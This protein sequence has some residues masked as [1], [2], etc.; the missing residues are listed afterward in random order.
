MRADGRAGRPVWWRPEVAGRDV[1]LALAAT[2][3]PLPSAV[4]ARLAAGQD[5]VG[6]LRPYSPD[7]AGVAATLGDLGLRFV[8][9]GDREWPLDASPPDPPCAWLFMAGRAPPGPDAAVAVVG[10]RRASPLR[11]AAA[12][13]LAAGLAAAGWWVVSGGAVGVDAAAH[14]GALDG[15]GRT[16]AVLGCGLDVV[17]PR[18]NGPLFARIVAEGGT[19]LSEHPPGAPPR[20]AHF[21]PR[22]RLIA[23]LAAAVVVVEAAEGSGSLSTA[24]AAGS[25]GRGRVLVVPGAPWDPGAAGSNELLRDGGTLVR[26]LDDILEELEA[27]TPAGGRNPP[28]KPWPQVAGPAARAVLQALVDGQVVGPARLAATTDLTPE[29]IADAVLEL[30]LAGLVR[31]TAAGFQFVA[32]PRPPGP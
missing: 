21:V 29:V 6:L 23:A 32:L 28:A 18:A 19:L 17:Y 3:G 16:V 25:R 13:S 27:P 12:R 10:G 9:P 26:G 5:P 7:P 2:S 8:V 31:R 24:R 30:E 22:N 15:R 14:A 4:A 11:R 1:L 20:A